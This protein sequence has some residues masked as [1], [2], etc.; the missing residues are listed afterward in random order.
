MVSWVDSGHRGLEAG[1][2]C[3]GS[4]S[5]VYRPANHVTH[6]VSPLIIRVTCTRS[7]PNGFAPMQKLLDRVAE[8]MQEDMMRMR[9][10][11]VCVWG[12]GEGVAIHGM[13]CI[14]YE[15]RGEGEGGRGY[16]AA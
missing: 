7:N 10:V 14:K 3:T 2:D 4:C 12:G 15:V 1:G 5:I 6:Q 16:L 13:V 11:C 9:Q 8:E